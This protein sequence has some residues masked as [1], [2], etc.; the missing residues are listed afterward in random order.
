MRYGKS[1]G[2]HEINEQ[3]RRR[4]NMSLKKAQPG[5]PFGW[6]SEGE[7]YKGTTYALKDSASGL[8][9]ASV[10]TR[11]AGNP[12]YFWKSLSDVSAKVALSALETHGTVRNLQAGESSAPAG[13]VFEEEILVKAERLFVRL[14]GAETVKRFEDAEKQAA[15]DARA[16]D[17]SDSDVSEPPDD[18]EEEVPAPDSNKMTP[19][20][21]SSKSVL[22]ES[23]AVGKKRLAR[24]ALADEIKAT[25]QANKAAR[26][27]ALD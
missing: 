8:K 11:N 4:P 25:Q 18:E 21:S 2:V 13:E 6:T 12:A 3:A 22:E 20:A 17:Q 16:D 19:S 7:P 24:M 26:P 10:S 15:A 9:F 1:A 14:L 23:K 27:V 5:A